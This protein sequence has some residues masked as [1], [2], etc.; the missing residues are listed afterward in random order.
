VANC[1][2]KI[3]VMRDGVIVDVRE[4]DKSQS[5]LMKA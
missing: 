1:T 4:P 5:L 3:Y 2:N